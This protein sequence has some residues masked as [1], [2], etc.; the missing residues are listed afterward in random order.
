MNKII[1]FLL[2]TLALSC[3]ENK[4]LNQ[5]TIDEEENTIMLIGE[6]NRSGLQQE[7]FKDW[8]TINYDNYKTDDSLIDYISTEIK[9]IQIKLFIGTWCEDSQNYTPEIYKILDEAN[10]DFNQLELIAVDR[11]KMTPTNHHIGLDIVYIPSMLFFKN[12]KELNRIVEYPRGTF[13][14]D[15]LKIIRGED[16]K[17]AYFE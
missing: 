16:Y 13:E 7:M 10:F 12:G 8:F 1:F 11:D 6:A 14:Q 15:I 2:F 4:K 5:T 3:G 9:D 17:H